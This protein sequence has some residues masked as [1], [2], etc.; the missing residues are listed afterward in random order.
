M[1][2]C[3]LMLV[4]LACDNYLEVNLAMLN[5]IMLAM[6]AQTK[7]TLIWVLGGAL[8]AM[9]LF[10]IVTILAQSGKDTQMSGAITG[11]AET[12]FGQ[13]KGNKRDRLFTKLTIAISIV[14]AIAVIALYIVAGIS[15]K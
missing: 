10:L 6:S 9:A 7:E 1:L 3:A 12:F 11:S 15:A 8:I 2:D 5:T 14:F 13:S 4:V